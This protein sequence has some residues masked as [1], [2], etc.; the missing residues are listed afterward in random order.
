MRSGCWKEPSSSPREATSGPGLPGQTWV[1]VQTGLPTCCVI[2]GKLL[3]LSEPELS[4][5]KQ[6]WW[7]IVSE[8]GLTWGSVLLTSVA[9]ADFAPVMGE[10]SIETQP[11]H[12]QMLS[13]HSWES[14]LECRTH[15]FG[16]QWEPLL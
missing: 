4:C 8:E 12:P 6:S 3:S 5:E 13:A 2:W 10:G 11:P 9:V 1:L 7:R 16:F 15:C 14:G